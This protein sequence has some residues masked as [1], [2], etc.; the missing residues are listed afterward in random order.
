VR[1]YCPISLIHIIGKLFSKVHANRLAPRFGELVHAN[2]STFIKGR[3]IQDNF[4][5]VQ[6]TAKMLQE[7]KKACLLLKIDIAR[8]FHLVAWVFLLEVLQHM[9]FTGVWREWISVLL[10]MASTKVLLNGNPV[11]EFVMCV[12][13]AKATRCGLCSFS[14]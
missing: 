1:D 3:F 8:A 11:I 9:E 14:L 5:M 6:M 7:K 10:S 13:S 2:Q 12:D 4:K